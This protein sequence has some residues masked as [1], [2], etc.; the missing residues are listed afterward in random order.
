MAL[1]SAP[2]K[3]D[4]ADI[5]RRHKASF[6][7]AFPMHPRQWKVLQNIINCRTAVLGGHVARCD[8]CGAVDYS[9]HSCRDRHCPKCQG[10]ARKRWLSARL[11]E[12]L[13]VPYFHVIFTMPN[14]LAELALQNKWVLYDILFK[15]SGEALCSI[16]EDPKHLGAEIGF[17]GILHS[18]G[19]ALSH[20]P[21]IHYIVPGGG[22][23]LD[24]QRWIPTRKNFL[25]SVRVLSLKFRTLFLGALRTAFTNGHLQFYGKL[26]HLEKREVFESWLNSTRATQWVV[27]SKTS[28]G[29]PETTLRYLARYAYRVAI[30]NHR[31]QSITDK[32]VTFEYKNYRTGEY[33]LLMTLHPHEFMRRF[34]LHVLPEGFVRIRYGGFLAPRHRTDKLA[35]CRTLLEQQQPTA[36]LSQLAAV[37]PNAPPTGRTLETLSDPL[38]PDARVPEPPPQKQSK[39]PRIGDIVGTCPICNQGH[40]VIV[41]VFPSELPPSA[42]RRRKRT[43]P[44]PSTLIWELA[45]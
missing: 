45:S 26:K 17:V 40:S 20:H 19:Q 10:L 33:D 2:P 42:R 18:W 41:E 31:I 14:T 30:S 29:G 5:F 12:L 35:L 37:P 6:A 24:G 36:S 34:L 23:S 32:S 8:R 1:V 27:H 43:R 9:Y 21:H 3:F 28:G 15:A 16:A 4:V 44:P 25:L 22:L 13:P 38:L 39:K 7:K 11:A